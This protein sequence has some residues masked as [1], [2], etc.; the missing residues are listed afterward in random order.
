MKRIIL[1][2]LVLI[3]LLK[4]FGNDVHDFKS[5]TLEQIIVMDINVPPTKENV[6][7][8]LHYY[9]VKHPEI[10][11]AQ[12]ILET[13][14]FKS[15]ACVL[16][17]NLFGLSKG[18]KLMRFHHWVES[19]KFYSTVIQIR[20]KPPSENYYQFLKRINYAEDNRYI[21]KISRIA[22]GL[23]A[24]FGC[25]NT[26]NTT[27]VDNRIYPAKYNLLRQFSGTSDYK[28]LGFKLETINSLW[29]VSNS[30]G[31]ALMFKS[32]IVKQMYIS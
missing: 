21:Q 28:I 18:G 20:Y 27:Y 25:K 16:Y 19:I 32:M 17:N 31:K 22:N 12:G 26:I 24:E 23:R 13:G 30:K 4:V 5:I 29:L 9:G 3:P 6:A 11:L 8:C 7:A 10:V 15:N 1:F 2:L 14:H